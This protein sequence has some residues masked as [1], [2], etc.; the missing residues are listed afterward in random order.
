MDKISII[1]PVYNA[2]AYLSRCVESLQA[3]THPN[4]EIIL[5]NDGSSDESLT[6]CQAFAE[7]DPRIIVM[8]QENQGQSVARNTGLAA[9]SGTYISFVDSDDYVNKNYLAHLYQDICQTGSDLAMCGFTYFFEEEVD[10]SV[11]EKTTQQTIL[12]D[13]DILVQMHTERDEPFVVVWGKLYKKSL[14]EG[15]FFPPGRIWEDYCVLYQLFDRARKVVRSNE[16]LYYYYRNNQDSATFQLKEKFYQDM[17]YILD[18]E[19]LYMEQ[20]GYE[21]IVILVK[22]RYLYWLI[23]YYKK[24]RK[25]DPALK[26]KLYQKYQEIY[27]SLR[28]NINEKMYRAF[29]YL[30]NIYCIVKS[31]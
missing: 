31:R 28:G 24:I 8:N 22:K 14:W 19:I 3:Q 9:A 15:I 21:D 27:L 11:L 6:I 1:V 23:D 13:H 18:E 5:V 29:S 7:K 20:R 25:T 17:M 30:P 16:I 2:K 12:T 10:E 4:L 26:V